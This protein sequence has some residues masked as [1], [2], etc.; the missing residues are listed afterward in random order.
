MD[1]PGT[2]SATCGAIIHASGGGPGM[3]NGSQEVTAFCVNQ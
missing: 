1:P 2:Y 3:G